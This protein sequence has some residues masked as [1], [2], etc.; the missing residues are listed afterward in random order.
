MSHQ[1]GAGHNGSNYTEF[2]GESTQESNY[3]CTIAKRKALHHYNCV[4]LELT[5]I[6]LFGKDLT[7]AQRME[8]FTLIRIE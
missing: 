6:V 1:W 8:N 4:S 5:F 7:L 3:V 2:Y